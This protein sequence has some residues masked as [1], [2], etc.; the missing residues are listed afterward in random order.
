MSKECFPTSET[1]FRFWLPRFADYFAEEG[2][3]LGFSAEEIASVQADADWMV[4]YIQMADEA[5]NHRA[6]MVKTRDLLRNGPDTLPPVQPASCHLSAPPTS[7]APRPGVL[8]R[9]RAAMARMMEQPGYRGGL[10]LA[11]HLERSSRAPSEQPPEFRVAERLGVAVVK[12][13]KAGHQGVIVECRRGAET[14][15]TRVAVRTRSP[16]KDER[17]VLVPGQPE[18]RTYRLQFF[19][20][21]EPV[22]QLSALQEVVLPGTIISRVRRTLPGGPGGAPAKEEAT[23]ASAPREPVAPGG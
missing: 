4:Y 22:G 7:P 3:G 20:A 2:P 19:D 1:G 10:K 11:A 17:P 15:F 23:P 5:K 13:R 8:P 6:G 16:F 18:L 12:F 21:D 9:L 14:A